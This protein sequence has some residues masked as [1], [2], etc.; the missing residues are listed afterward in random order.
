MA[1]CMSIISRTGHCLKFG[2]CIAKDPMRCSVECVVVWI[3]SF[4]EIN[5]ITFFTCCS[6][7]YSLRRH[8]E[9]H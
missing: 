7:P 6:W 8:V 2:R 1:V 4:L 5:L 3:N 9:L